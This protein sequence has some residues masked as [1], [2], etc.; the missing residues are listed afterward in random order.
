[1]E[2]LIQI[3]QEK[4][5]DNPVLV[6]NLLLIIKKHYG[7]LR[8]YELKDRNYKFIYGGDIHDREI[9]FWNDILAYQKKYP[10]KM[11][12]RFFNWWSEKTLDGKKMKW[13]REKTFEIGKRLA[14]WWAKQNS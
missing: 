1:M 13:E 6:K 3:I 4:G 9:I 2:E 5:K 14:T 7:T 10:I 11:L 12:E 8:A